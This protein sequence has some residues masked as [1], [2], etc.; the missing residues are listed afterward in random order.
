MK[1]TNPSYWDEYSNLQFTKHKLI[2]EYLKGWFPKLG[3]WCGNI[4]YIDTHAGRGRH[5]GGQEGS[6][7]I[8]LKTFLNHTWRERILKTCKIH[9]VFI[10]ADKE[11]AALLDQEL[12]SLG[13]LP[14]GI[15]VRTFNS[16]AFDYLKGLTDFF[17]QRNAKLV[18]CLVFV[19]PYG[20]KIPCDILKRIKTHPN[21]ELLVTFIWR[22]L[23]MAI[24]QDQP[25]EEVLN[26]VFGSQDWR[27]IRTIADFDAR[28]D[29]AVKLLR[30]NIG[31]KW[32]TYIRMFGDNRKTR[33][34]LVHLTDHEAGRELMKEV[35][36]KCCPEG[37]YYVRKTD[38]PKQQY[39][40]KP[41]PDL[42]PLKKWALDKLSEKS[43]KWS[44]LEERIRSEV[45][46]KKHLG[47]IIR[48][49]RE[50]G[51]VTG[52]GKFTRTADPVLSLM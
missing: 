32:A 16:D 43:Y 12:Q 39:L 45:W 6:P 52:I 31:A 10:E 7:L 5:K 23:D 20:F 22:E 38:D 21:S 19:D 33:Y 14:M 41:E 13:S 9:F 15:K 30:D 28:G 37:G 3:S 29:A 49:L 44:E 40:I 2:E 35:A 8:A 34:F 46:L 1:D 48:S 50:E 11:N 18:P 27:I 42:H 51:K 26:S 4:L 25:P 36:W 17:D 24:Q 47:Q